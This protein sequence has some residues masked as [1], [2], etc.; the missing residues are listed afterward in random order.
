MR[1]TCR[2]LGGCCVLAMLL[3]MGCRQ[4]AEND[5]SQDMSSMSL[6]ITGITPAQDASSVGLT[7]SIT[8]E[9]S[10]PVQWIEGMQGELVINPSVSGDLTLTEEGALV[11]SPSQ[12]S[13]FAPS[14]SYKVSLATDV[15]EGTGGARLS[16]PFE[17]FFTTAATA[18]SLDRST[19]RD[20]TLAQESRVR[21]Y[22]NAEGLLDYELETTAPLLDG[23]PEG[24][25]L[26]VSE[27][28]S[29]PVLRSGNTIFDALFALSMQEVRD[30]RVSSISD[31]AFN[32]GQGVDCECFETGAKWNYVWTRDTAY[33]VDLGL[34][35]IDPER[36]MNSLDFKLSPLKGGAESSLQIV[37][38]TGTGGSWPVSTD[39]VVWAIGAAR[40]LD[41]LPESSASDF[42]NRT[43]IALKNTVE[44]D[45][46]VVF[47]A[48]DGLYRGEQSF[49]DWREQ[50]YPLWTAQDT[51]HIAES[52]SFSTNV[53]HL[54]ALRL[55]AKLATR[56]GEQ[57]SAARY[58]E[59][60]DALKLA[61]EQ[62]FWLEDESSYSAM[63]LGELAP[64]ALKKYD[65]LG[66]SLWALS[67]DADDAHIKQAV[68]SYPHLPMGPPVLWPQQ[69]NVPIYH[70]RGIWPFVTAYDLLAAKRLGNTSVFELD[71][72]SLI[73]G[74][75]LN[76]SNMENFEA[77]RQ[78]AWFDDGAFSGPVVNSRRQLWSVA[79]Y[80]GAILRGVIGVDVQDDALV[81][82][83]FVFP[84]LHERW[85]KES[86]SIVLSNFMWKG[87]SIDIDV[88]L[89]GL[90]GVQ[91]S[92]AYEVREIRLN[93]DVVSGGITLAMLDDENQ[94]QVVLEQGA[95]ESSD[96]NLVSDWT[97][98]RELFAPNQPV[99]DSVNEN[100]ERGLLE[101]SFSQIDE[102]G[103]V[104]DVWRNGTQ[105]AQGLT[106]GSWVD[107][108]SA[109][110][111]EEVFCYSVLARF[112]SSGH[113]SNPSRPVCYWGDRIQQLS[114]VSFATAEGGTWSEEHGQAHYQDWGDVGDSLELHAWRARQDGPHLIQFQYGN[115]SGGFNTGITASVKQVVLM[116]SITGEELARKSV[117]MPQLADWGRW[118]ESSLVRFD[119]EQG[120]D[121]RIKVEDGINMSYFQHFSSYTG[122]TGGGD[123]VFN[124][125]NIAGI[126]ILPLGEDAERSARVTFD[127]VDD[128]GDVPQEQQYQDVGAAMES[129]SA[130][131]L[132]WDDEY[133]YV[134][135]VS[136]AF[137]SQFKA[138]MLYLEGAQGA[139]G[140]DA[141]PGQGMGYSDLTPWVPFTPSYVV[142]AR[143]Q[144]Q[145]SVT[146]VP[147][148]GAYMLNQDGGWD[149][150]FGFAP[151]VHKWSSADLHTLSLRVPIEVVGS[152]DRIRLAGHVVFEQA[153]QEWKELFPATHTPWLEGGGQFFEVDLGQED[154]SS[155]NWVLKPNV[156]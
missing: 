149:R 141:S 93:G 136:P 106:G 115:G 143:V 125:V 14:T 140:V 89:P 65:L 81:V 139:F 39:R 96:V 127:G 75:A 133:L 57:E 144:E 119:L 104:Y 61:I 110:R 86:T 124:R 40:L 33:A 54:S 102:Q 22:A 58:T 48:Q 79:G 128:L 27:V 1:R 121:Y 35:M 83:P 20:E 95:V 11:W 112:T 126:K 84:S 66:Q 156:P 64:Q 73:R 51:V 77:T 103:V 123:D 130:W 41:Y 71:L 32:Y 113:E 18:S 44:Q 45:R 105:V 146:E 21:A 100:A 63:K 60:A 137:E 49:L 99:L 153:G 6:E 142:S 109:G 9:F 3:C 88:V 122:G 4:E 10:E 131:G 55:A 62:E 111:N 154:H 8:L 150:V 12:G 94:L 129:W 70:N 13:S 23:G 120:R 92:G 67:G 151:G 138:V 107:E 90:D 155:T 56:Q 72:E 15:V 17:L 74:A 25:T 24:N 148:S 82:R 28:S 29:M 108:Q 52:K 36:A 26:T 118:G 78:A 2:F 43:Y 38:D 76:L 42:A 80:A 53:G 50:S 30:N 47:D 145:G 69:P 37:Q 5:P 98:Y 59:W 46:Q 114:T 34:G 85:F 16:A 87:K 7:Q 101:L 135:I 116:D 97:D 68:S 152:P 91:G 117:V 31:G 132:D 134:V 19:Y 147:W